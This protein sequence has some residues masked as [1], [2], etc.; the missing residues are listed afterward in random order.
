MKV[1]LGCVHDP[2]DYLYRSVDPNGHFTRMKSRGCMAKHP[3]SDWIDSRPR[4][5]IDISVASSVLFLFAIPM[6]VIALCIRLTSEGDALFS[7][8]RIGMYGQPFRIYK[9]RSLTTSDGANQG[10]GLIRGEG[11]DNN[12]GGTHSSQVQAR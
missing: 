7:Q 3:V 1:K 11:Q 6:A 12:P 5:L 4:R 9:F 10:S 8:M 2:L